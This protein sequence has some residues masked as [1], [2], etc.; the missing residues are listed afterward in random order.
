MSTQLTTAQLATFK[1]AIK[2]DAALAAFLAG[3]NAQAIADYYNAKAPSPPNVWRPSITVQELNTAV[4]WAAFAALTALKQTAY[5]AMTQGGFV[6]ATSTGVR[7]GFQAVFGAGTAST[8]ALNA[9]AQRS[10]TRFEAVF[11]TVS[12]TGNN[13][14]LFGKTCSTDDVAAAV[15]NDDGSVK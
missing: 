10:A 14:P 5:M 7:G 15:F 11:A 4:D 3:A 8:N 6:D 9:L 1:T 2:G 13:S 12:G